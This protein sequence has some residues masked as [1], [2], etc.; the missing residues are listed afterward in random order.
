MTSTPKWRGLTLAAAVI[1]SGSARGGDWT[2]YRHD[3]SGT[4]NANETL[5]VE[6]ARGF[7]VKWSVR[8]G[9]AIGNPVVVGGTLFV[10]GIDGSLHVLDAETGAQRW[11]YNSAAH[12]P[13]NCFPGSTTSSTKGPIGA[14]AVVGDTVF[15]PGGNGVVYAHDVD[16]GAIRWQTQVADVPALGEFLWSS[17]FPVNGRIY[18]GISSLH[19]CLLVPGRVVALDQ[20][21]GAV[22]ATWWADASHGP[23]GGVW[24]QPAYDPRTNRIFFTTGTIA[25]GLEPWQQ[26]LADAFV[27]ADATTLQTVDYHSPVDAGFSA[28]EDF[29]ASPL[30]YDTPDGRRWIV[31]TNKNG[32]VYAL[33]R[34]HLSNG[35][36]WSY[37]VSGYSGDPD[38]GLSS[39]VSPAWGNGTV[40]VG[41]T[42]TTDGYSGAVAA[43]DPSTGQ[44]KWVLH[45]PN[46]GFLLAAPTVVGDV[47]IFGA[48]Q[49][50]ASTNQSKL[51]VVAQSTGEILFEQTL[52]G[53]IFAEPTYANGVLYAGDLGGYVWAL[54]PGPAAQ[55]GGS[56]AGDGGV[57]GDGGTGDPDGGSGEVDPPAGKCGCSTTGGLG[58]ALM[59]VLLA[60][61][62]LLRRRV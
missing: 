45:P 61:A 15:M 20:A 34:D 46:G 33:D 18:L 47:V 19:D 13:F 55:D 5:T 21:T 12:G 57:G 9:G 49:T 22:V 31:A 25:D 53:P 17:A 32:W 3:V 59:F 2:F 50:L 35:T 8:K 41:G 24:T 40:F 62:A 28:D 51:Y 38:L 23:G 10:T 43:L 60:G 52:N 26:P 1:L 14:P 6:Q 54:A 48:T 42:K 29:G 7:T 58:G 37:Q 30:L 27:A 36:V 39:I 16:G 56:G 11:S 4:S 44:P